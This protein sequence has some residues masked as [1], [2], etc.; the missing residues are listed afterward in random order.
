MPVSA[1]DD[2]RLPARERLRGRD[3]F[4]ALFADGVVG[5]ARLVVV[6]A[7]PNDLPYSRLAVIAGRKVGKAHKRARI[8]RR[9]RAA[10]RVQKATLPTGYDIAV[11]PRY[12]VEDAP[13]PLLCA[14]LAKAARRAAGMGTDA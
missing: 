10:W 1:P 6:R 12:G 11:L 13:F 2:Q 14:D 5:K 3:R 7:L 8:R 9:L 4:D